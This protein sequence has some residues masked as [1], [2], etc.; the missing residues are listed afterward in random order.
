M[1]FEQV[2]LLLGLLGGAIFGTFQIMKIAPKFTK[3]LQLCRCTSQKVWYTI[4]GFWQN[5]CRKGPAEGP[6]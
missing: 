3:T 5:F 1:T 4:R 2:V 6:R